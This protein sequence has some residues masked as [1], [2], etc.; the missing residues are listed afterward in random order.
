[1]TRDGWKY[2]T[3]EGQPWLMFNL[4]EDPYEQ[5]NLAFEPRYR[6]ERDRLRAELAGWIDRTGDRFSL[7]AG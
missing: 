2:V 4:G 6:S 5:V 1:M 3:L 7:P